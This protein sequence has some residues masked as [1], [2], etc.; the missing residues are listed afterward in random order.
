MDM[1]VSGARQH[2]ARARPK[3]RAKRRMVTVEVSDSSVEKTMAPIVNTSEVATSEVMRPV[4]IGVPSEVSIKV[5]ADIPA[6][7]LKEGTELVSP[8]SLSSEQTR[9]AQGEGTPQ[10]KMNEDLEKE[11]TLSEEILE[12][13]VARV[14]GTV[15]EAEGITLP[16]SPVE[17]VRPEEGEKTSGEDVKTLEITFS[18]FLHDSVVPL[19]KY[20]DEKRVKYAVTEEPGFYVPMIRNRT[21]LKRAVAVKREW[22]SA[23]ALV[24]EREAQL[25]EKETECKVLQQNLEKESGRCAE[26][27]EACRGLCISNENVQKVTVDLVARLEKSREAYEAASK[28]SERLIITV[29]KREKIH[30][31]E[32]AKLEARRPEEAHIAE[33]LRGKLADTKTA[34]EDLRRKISEIEAKFWIGKGSG[35]EYG[36]AL[37]CE[38]SALAE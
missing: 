31:E 23:T 20:L 9:S 35:C 34:E 4:E 29:E 15:V 12:Q 24:R 8:I 21:K 14:G 22:E 3:K 6:E 10:M 32:L 27:E 5:P 38:S 25:R 33:E 16:T 36:F 17:E 37:P 28:R 18:E 1:D 13:V 19:L 26:L 7:P 2:R 30:I 11:F